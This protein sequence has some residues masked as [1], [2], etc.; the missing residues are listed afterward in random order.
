[1][2]DFNN[3][4]NREILFFVGI[5][6]FLTVFKFTI[7]SVDLSVNAFGYPK[8]ADF[9]KDV[10]GDDYFIGF[11]SY[12]WLSVIEKNPENNSF[13][14]ML[15]RFGFSARYFQ[16]IYVMLSCILVYFIIRK[17]EPKVALY[18]M[19]IFFINSYLYGQTLVGRLDH[20]ASFMFFF[21]LVILSICYF[22]W[23][24]ILISFIVGIGAFQLLY[25]P[26]VRISYIMDKLLVRGIITGVSEY[27]NAY[28]NSYYL[29]IFS[30]ILIGTLIFYWF[31]DK[32]KRLLALTI[33]FG[34]LTIVASYNER[35]QIFFLPLYIILIS[36]I[37]C[38]LLKILDLNFVFHLVF[39]TILL[40]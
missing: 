25:N 2:K 34:L 12:A 40:Y 21:L 30:I 15:V 18:G 11:D 22:K 20:Q 17:F 37:G 23:W 38:K 32:N 8:I 7:P 10:N 24:G 16:P 19:M 26:I 1:M 31:K 6:M 13:I 36:I 4:L 28:F 33:I 39:V 27:N 29:L 3:K 9:Y 35:I 14:P 5:F